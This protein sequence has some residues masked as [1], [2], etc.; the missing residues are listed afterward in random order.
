MRAR[1]VRRGELHQ[2]DG[3]KV[4]HQVKKKR[5][6]LEGTARSLSTS[7]S[8]RLC[9]QGFGGSLRFGALACVP[10][11]VAWRMRGSQKSGLRS[12]GSAPFQLK[13]YISNGL[14]CAAAARPHVTRS[15]Y[16]FLPPASLA[17][18]KSCAPHPRLISGPGCP[19]RRPGPGTS[20]HTHSTPL[21]REGRDGTQSPRKWSSRGR[22]QRARR[23][24]PIPS[25]RPARAPALA[26]RCG[27]R[28]ALGGEHAGARARGA[29]WR[30]C[31]GGRAGWRRRSPWRPPS[32]SRRW[33]P[34]AAAA[35]PPPSRPPCRPSTRAT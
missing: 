31:G 30:G 13:T 21:A 1:Q 28:E 15:S 23:P 34:R 18:H 10:A 35:A 2:E 8:A 33:S 14:R 26:R 16:P 3:G 22:H 11:C 7:S 24:V 20:T 5:L 4:G 6:W 9:A 27:A 17:T 32:G 12:L 19:H 25:R 29:R